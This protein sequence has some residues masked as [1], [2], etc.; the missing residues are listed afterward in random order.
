M[1]HDLLQL[2]TIGLLQQTQT[3]PEL[4]PGP[5]LDR[6][7]G[8]VEI[9]VLE[10][11]QIVAIALLIFAIAGLLGWILLQ[12]IRKQTNLAPIA[13]KDAA[14]AELKSAAETTDEDDE[15]F[16]VLSSL[17]LRRYFEEGKGIQ[18]LGKTTEE[19]LKRLN[20][21]TC[22]T[23]DSRKS[24]A[25]FMQR[26]DRVKFAQAPL[27]AAERLELTESALELIRNCE[28]TA[29]ATDEQTTHS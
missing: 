13:P 24:L 25:A 27:T 4:P 15:R 17:A 5:S 1:L 7:R 6:M 9:P 19:F 28:A 14:L 26:C 10:P 21:H 11:W 16:A 29:T 18:A 23:E 20:E 2:P 8:P 22:L 12:K 3:V